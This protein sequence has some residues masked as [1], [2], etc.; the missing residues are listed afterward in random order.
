MKMKRMLAFLLCV[1]TVFTFVSAEVYAVDYTVTVYSWDGKETFLTVSVPAGT[2]VTFTADGLTL[3]TGEKYTYSGDKEFLGFSKY[4]SSSSLDFAAGMTDTVSYDRK[5]YIVEAEKDFGHIV[6]GDLIEG[7]T[8]YELYEKSFDMELPADYPYYFISFAADRF[9]VILLK[10]PVLMCKVSSDRVSV[11]D[12]NGK[13]VYGYSSISLRDAW[14]QTIDKYNKG[15]FSTSGYFLA[16][17]SDID[18][19]IYSNGTGYQCGSLYSFSSKEYSV[20]YD[21][22]QSSDDLYFDLL[23]F[24]L[25][26]GL[27]DF[28]VKAK[29][30]G[31][32]DSAFSNTV[33]YLGDE[34]FDIDYD[35]MYASV[36]G[37]DGSSAPKKVIINR[38]LS[39]QLTPMPGYLQPESVSVTMGGTELTASQYKYYP[40]TG[41][42]VILKVTGDVIITAQGICKVAAPVIERDSGAET[43]EYPLVLTFDAVENASGY[44]VYVDGNK[45]DSVVISENSGVVSVKVKADVFAS[46][47]GSRN[48]YVVA[49]PVS[50]YTSSDASN[51][52]SVFVSMQVATPVAASLP[53]LR[54]EEYPFVCSV[55]KPEHSG[56][57]VC[58]VNDERCNAVRYEID[59]D[60]KWIVYFSTS[61]FAGSGNYEIY[62]VALGETVD[63]VD[64]ESSNSLTFTIRQLSTPVI[65]LE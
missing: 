52:L 9:N 24:D 30:E 32:Y 27:H 14:N 38:P 10:E 34:R 46:G 7:A 51:I 64:S 6:R 65:W 53:D 49:E 4:S 3:P 63:F 25:S 36:V 39:V 21:L 54:T 57:L 28:V 58:Y 8:S 48:V 29:G 60:G 22:L 13:V 55:T 23:T 56:S 42:L 15:D 43:G 16:S 19:V 59:D 1:A 5:Y 50:G 41:N 35:L 37:A 12:A 61:A 33:H 31:Y 45:T 11:S 44:S 40:E 17:P 2:V 47:S 18:N 62:F 20:T 26:A